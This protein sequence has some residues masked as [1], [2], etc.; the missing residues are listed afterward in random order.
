MGA[1]LFATEFHAKRAGTSLPSQKRSAPPLGS[2]DFL[3]GN[4]PI[5]QEY[6]LPND[7]AS[8]FDGNRVSG[9]AF[10]RH[11]AGGTDGFFQVVRLIEAVFGGFTNDAISVRVPVS[12]LSPEPGPS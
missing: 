12:L 2:V 6:H 4:T 11:G 9:L 5:R 3:V 10:A 1:A 8:M 7:P